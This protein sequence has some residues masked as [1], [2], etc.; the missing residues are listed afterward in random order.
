MKEKIIDGVVGGSVILA[1]VLTILK[2]LGVIT[3][4]LWVVFAPVW[5]LVSFV[6]TVVVVASVYIVFRMDWWA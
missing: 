5:L 4:P 2:L 3:C 6:V 1:I